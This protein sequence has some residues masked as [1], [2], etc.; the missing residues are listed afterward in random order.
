MLSIIKFCVIMKSANKFT[1][2][3]LNFSVPS[4]LMLSVKLWTVIRHYTE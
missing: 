2:I 3:T 1:T 4:V